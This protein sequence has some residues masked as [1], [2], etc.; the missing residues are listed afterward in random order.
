MKQ[1][2]VLPK[3]RVPGQPNWLVRGLWIAGLFV[4]VW[5]VILGLQ[6]WRRGSAQPLVARPRAATAATGGRR[7]PAP[8]GAA[9]KSGPV[10]ASA[11]ESAPAVPGAAKAASGSRQGFGG[12]F[13]RSRY[14][15]GRRAARA[16]QCLGQ[17]PGQV[18]HGRA[19]GG[20]RAQGVLAEKASAGGARGRGDPPG[21]RPAEH[22]LVRRAH[23]FL[24][25]RPMMK[26]A[27][28]KAAG[29]DRAGKGDPIDE[30]LPQFQ[31]SGAGPTPSH[32]QAKIGEDRPGSDR[33]SGCTP[34]G[35]RLAARPIPHGTVPNVH[36]KKA[37]DGSTTTRRELSPL[38]LQ[39]APADG[40]RP[41]P[42]GRRRG[43]ARKR[44]NVGRVRT[45]ERRSREEAER[46]AARPRS[47]RV[48][49]RK[50]GWSVSGKSS[51]GWPRPNAARGSRARCACSKSACASRC[52]RARSDRPEG[53]PDRRRCHGQLF[54]GAVYK[55]KSDAQAEVEAQRAESI[56]LEQESA[57][58]EQEQQRKY[59]AMVAEG[60]GPGRRPVGGRAQKIRREM[61]E[62]RERERVRRAQEN[63]PARPAS[64]P[65]PPRRPP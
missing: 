29:E 15:G 43:R 7:R 46:L 51:C 47:A 38:L 59:Q 41:H 16:G 45:A 1:E 39:R 35:Q 60:K 58:R 11:P 57:R 34:G 50:S 61:E 64:P 53:D 22:P 5:V 48:R 13:G 36:P 55:L 37:L 25:K 28:G 54:G 33:G 6:L 2:I 19:S 63:A 20:A 65:A 3:L 62:A 12:Q 40:G 52:S 18:T 8:A 32:G 44:P 21:L 26:P 4:S 10:P 42:Q 49:P 31:V 9:T 56:R 14:R 30:I 17:G 24:A 23:P 27:T